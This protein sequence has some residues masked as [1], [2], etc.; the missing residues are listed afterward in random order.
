MSDSGLKN[1]VVVPRSVAADYRNGRI[2]RAELQT[3]L[4][5]RINGNPYGIAHMSLETV[6]EDVF[7]SSKKKNYVNKIMLSLKSKRYIFYEQRSGRRGSFEVHFGEWII[8]SKDEAGKPIIKNLDY[9]F[10][11]AAV[12]RPRLVLNNPH[13]EDY[14]E[15]AL[16]FQSLESQ[17]EQ[18][19]VD[20]STENDDEAFRSPDNDTD[21]ENDTETK[22]TSAY[23][24]RSISLDQFVPKSY[25]EELCLAF[26]KELG[27]RDMG[28]ILG[29]LKKHGIRIIEVAFLKTQKA[30]KDEFVE[31]P[32]KLFNYLVRQVAEESQWI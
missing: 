32:C 10:S 25:E 24:R 13:S 6:A 3:Y 18:A 8:P 20:D 4:W 16:Q 15:D 17:N 5:M 1:Y 12:R 29:S 7:G 21:I 22:R 30:M 23:G 2:N 26:A 31:D 11:D 27:E 14:A 19:D 28:F 9:L